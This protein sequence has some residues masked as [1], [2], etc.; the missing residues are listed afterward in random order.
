MN[1]KYRELKKKYAL[2]VP[3]YLVAESLGY[4]MLLAY[5]VTNSAPLSANKSAVMNQLAIIP[6]FLRK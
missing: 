4:H 3:T 5:R 6:K 2:N 1:K